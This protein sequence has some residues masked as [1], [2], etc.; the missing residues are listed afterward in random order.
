[1]CRMAL[2]HSLGKLFF[3]NSLVSPSWVQAG[4][5]LRCQPHA[6][7]RPSGSP[8]IPGE[9]SGTPPQQGCDWDIQPDFGMLV[10]VTGAHQALNVFAL[11]H[12][13]VVFV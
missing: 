13:Q 7:N 8:C 3:P 5:G 10:D 6:Q 12:P 11:V 9:W 2:P 1:M 4:P